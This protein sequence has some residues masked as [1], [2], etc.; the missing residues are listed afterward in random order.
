MDR[1]R[2]PARSVTTV[3][4]DRDQ[5]LIFD[6]GPGGRIRVL[7]GST[8]LTEEGESADGILQAGSERALRRGRTLIEGLG[9]ARV[10]IAQRMRR[11]AAP[12]VA[13][14]RGVWRGIGHQVARL[15]F[16]PASAEDTRSP[17]PPWWPRN[18]A[19]EA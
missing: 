11:S 4:L 8:W 15:Q 2:N 3:D 17:L 9:P 1:M 14:L 12:P 5:M 19:R 10:Q 16:G 6:G 7:R 18:P 13:W